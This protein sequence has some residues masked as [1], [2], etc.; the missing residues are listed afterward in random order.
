[1]GGGGFI[2]SH[3]AKKLKSLGA[4]VVCVDVAKSEYMEISE[5]AHEFRFADMRSAAVACSVL[6]GYDLVFNFAADMGGM[7]FISKNGRAI[8]ETNHTIS[9][10][11]L[12]AACDS[13]ASR[14]FYASSACVYPK[15][16]QRTSSAA[17]LVEE[18]AWPAEP[19]SGYGLEKLIGE[20]I[21]SQA[22]QKVPTIDMPYRNAHCALKSFVRA[23]A[24]L[25]M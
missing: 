4:Y 15:S 13:K 23:S 3:V 14:I 1:V 19:D 5:Y 11:V 10:N 8:L 22:S 6:D 21:A 9:R 7:G 25:V 17:G 20:W 24:P 12:Y 2:G 18:D 16:K